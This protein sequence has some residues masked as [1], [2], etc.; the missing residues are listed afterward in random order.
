VG[1]SLD[2]LYSAPEAF[3]VAQAYVREA[4]LEE[5]APDNRTLVLDVV[6][7]DAL[8]KGVVKKGELYPTTLAKVGKLVD[9]RLRP[10]VT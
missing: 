1:A 2:A 3:E 10:A 6:L 4:R 9:R 7:C 8:F 5:G